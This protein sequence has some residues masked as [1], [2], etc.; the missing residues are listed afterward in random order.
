MDLNGT[1]FS[2]HILT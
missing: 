2:N 1:A